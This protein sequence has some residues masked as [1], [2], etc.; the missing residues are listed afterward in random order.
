MMSAAEALAKIEPILD[1][2]F[3]THLDVCEQCRSDP[4]RLCPIGEQCLQ[5][6]A[7]RAIDRLAREAVELLDPQPRS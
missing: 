1:N 7:S 3:H 2:C 5:I 6:A 4:M